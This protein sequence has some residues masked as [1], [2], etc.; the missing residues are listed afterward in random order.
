MLR[1]R[2]SRLDAV[3]FT[4]SHKDHTAGLDDVRAFN[5]LQRA[6]MPVY[7]T[8]EVLEHLK[9]EFYYA[10][11]P[12][13]YPGIPQ[14][15]LNQITDTPFE[16]NG[17]QFTPLPVMHLQLPVLGFRIGDF[18]YITDANFIPDETLAK[19]SGTR[20]LVLNALQREK[21]AS[22]FNLDEAI[23]Q[24]KVIGANLTYFT[25]ISHRLG[26]H[27]T[28]ERELP[29]SILLAYDGLTLTL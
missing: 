10:F 7:A 22:H 29:P 3:I 18:S 19:L 16:I 26:Q 15:R 1:E 9:V 4:H 21:H 24:A 8:N 13:R 25:H 11:E 17:I 27:K 14:L 23:E 28:I 6:D 20:I 2:I 5:Y 12:V